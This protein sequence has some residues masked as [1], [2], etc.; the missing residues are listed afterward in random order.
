VN[1]KVWLKEIESKMKNTLALLLEQAV[2]ED[3][4]TSDRARFVEWATKFPAQIMIL[5][6]QIRWSM[7]VDEALMS[8]DCSRALQQNLS[9]LEWKLSVMAET[10][11]LELPPES[12]KKFEQMFT[13]LVHQRDVVR[14]LIEQNVTSPK[15]FRWLYHL[16]YNY[17]PEAATHTQTSS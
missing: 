8:D 17:N 7:G 9:S 3:K 14:D 13:E 4:A 1:V 2:S 10:V 6:T 12:R 16:R 11:L 5:A 15:D